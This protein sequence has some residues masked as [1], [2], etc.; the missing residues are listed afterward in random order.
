MYWISSAPCC[1]EYCLR[2]YSTGAYHNRQAR[3]SFRLKAE[4]T[5]E[6]GSYGAGGGYGEG[7]SDGAS[8]KR[9]RRGGRLRDPLP[10]RI[11]PRVERLVSRCSVLHAARFQDGLA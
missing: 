7:G 6:G 9:R 11:H 1:K 3:A 8:R 5:G 2:R 4:A 10:L